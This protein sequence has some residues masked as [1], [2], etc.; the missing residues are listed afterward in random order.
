MSTV[1]SDGTE[2]IRKAFVDVCVASFAADD[3][4]VSEFIEYSDHG[5]ANDV[6]VLQ[7]YL[8]ALLPDSE[9]ERLLENF[10]I[11]KGCWKDIDYEATASAR[12]APSLHATR[13][14]ALAKLYKA[15]DQKWQGSERLSGVLHAGLEYWFETMP[16]CSNWWYNEIGVPKKMGA[17]LL[18]LYDELSQEELEG[19]LR[20][21][22]HSQ[23][24]GT[25]QNKVWLAGNVLMRALLTDDEDLLRQA[26][27]CMAEEISVSS[28]EGIQEDWAFHQHGPQ[29]QMGNYGLAFADAIAFWARVFAGTEYTFADYQMSTFGTFLKEGLSRCVY[30]GVMDPNFCGRQNFLNGG[31]GKAYAMDIV[32]A[33]MAE[34]ETKSAFEPEESGI[35]GLA[36]VK[37]FDSSDCGICRRTD[38]YAS[39]RMHSERTIGFEFT[40][41]ENT[42]ANFSADGVLLLM[43]DGTEYENIFAYWDWRKL[44]GVT[45]Y[46]DGRPLKSDDSILAKRNWTEHVGG[47]TLGNVMATSMELD[48]DGL[49]ALKTNF[50][51]GDCIVS[52]GA[53]IRADNP[54]FKSVTT[55]VDQ[56]H[57]N[58]EITYCKSASSAGANQYKNVTWV[59]HN[60][61]GYI[62]LDGGKMYVSDALQKGKWDIMEPYFKNK[63]DEG[64]VFKCWFEHP[65][66]NLRGGR[67][68]SYAYAIVPCASDSQIASLAK[69]LSKGGKKSP[70]KVLSNTADCQAVLY[71]ETLCAA[72]HKAGSYSFKAGQEY[73]SIDV[74]QPCI[75]IRRAG[76][77]EIV[78]F[79]EE[80]ESVAE[81]VFDRAA[82]QFALLDKNIEAAESAA[83]DSSTPL[84]PRT[85][86]DQGRLVTSDMMWW[87]SG[88]FPGSL[89]YLYEYT[90]E[91]SWKELALK[92]TLDL[93]PLRHRETDHDVGFQIMSSY[94]NAL[95]LT[96]NDEYESVIKDAAYSLS[97]RFNPVVGCTRSWDGN[98]WKF[99]VIIDN[100]MNLELLFEGARLSGDESLSNIA[101][102]HAQTTMLNH[103]RADYSTFHLV[104]Y[105]PKTGEVIGK[106]TVQGFADD[107]AWSRGQAWALYGYTMVYRFS[108]DNKFL[109][110]AVHIADYLLPRLPQDGIPY[111]D[112]DSDE[113]PDDYRDASAAAIMASALIELSGYTDASRALHYQSIARKIIRTLAS[114]EYLAGKGEAQGFLL[115]HSVGNKR[116]DS[117]V[118]VPLTYA[119]Y[120]FLEAL[121]RYLALKK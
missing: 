61:R 13:L 87:C 78:P 46:D 36:E 70:V 93:D 82:S 33:N 43:Q 83:D 38:W 14:Q 62:S 47:A 55:A 76:E 57:L 30:G 67:S 10:D 120:Y 2:M 108:Q 16:E 22:E 7:L 92:Y 48:R 39:V 32:E 115:K 75:L 19:G 85:I 64:R 112:F 25:G 44:P 84:F 18:M 98:S 29:I 49:H 89:W 116:G 91:T 20:V 96:G 15:P 81:R 59:H 40:N 58:G 53:D 21:M 114:A 94:G 26:R 101:L 86:D 9:V 27:D 79:P 4:T 5:R 107:S 109:D 11:D 37:Y 118:D 95:R 34:A 23:F 102:T 6:M 52:L 42:P 104:N 106:Q 105:D 90:G 54:D 80:I 121:L 24:G 35:A 117:E 8:A 45:A 31:R 103:F 66:G 69:K 63:T 72:V 41:G 56:T 17:V 119:D 12:W 71:D 77:Q 51:F 3:G 110:Q 111:W 50:F 100:M 97:K 99:P 1:D 60:N 68:E 74:A 88:F 28:G 113:I 73:I 65:L